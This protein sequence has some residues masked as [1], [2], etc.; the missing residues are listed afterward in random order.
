MLDTISVFPK[1]KF[2]TSTFP[3][4][5]TS[6][7]YPARGLQALCNS[8]NKSTKIT[9]NRV[10]LNH[11]S[12]QTKLLRKLDFSRL[13]GGFLRNRKNL[14]QLLQGLICFDGSPNKKKGFTFKKKKNK[15]S[16][17][18]GESTF[19]YCLLFC[20]SHL[21]AGNVSTWVSPA[22]DASCPATVTHSA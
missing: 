10:N 5:S 14:I 2:N 9:A 4:A 20:V 1:F 17:H 22:T 21:H 15:L 18:G 13:K 7:H 16:S 6:S 11:L 19:F 3:K 12:T 8:S